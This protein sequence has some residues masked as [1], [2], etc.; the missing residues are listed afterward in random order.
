MASTTPHPSTPRRSRDSDKIGSFQREGEIG[1]GSFATVYKAVHTVS[2][3]S[4]GSSPYVLC[5]MD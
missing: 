1:K 5:D 2:S 3:L 4:S